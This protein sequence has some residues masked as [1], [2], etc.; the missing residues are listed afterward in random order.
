MSNVMRARLVVQ[1]CLALLGAVPISIAVAAD[2]ATPAHAQ[3]AVPADYT[4]DGRLTLTAIMSR[5]ETLSSQH[6]WQSET[7]YAYPDAPDVTI[8][9]WRTARQGEALWFLSGIH[10]EE[11]S[12][13]RL[14]DFK[15]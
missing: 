8:K 4:A 10:G 9:S 7:I 13:S 1:T 3:A 14:I 12:K 15:Q 6:G 5:F 11:P 2:A